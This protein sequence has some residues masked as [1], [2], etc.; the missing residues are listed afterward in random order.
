MPMCVSLA[1]GAMSEA[2]IPQPDS[3]RDC[4]MPACCSHLLTHLS[5]SPGFKALLLA[6]CLPWKVVGMDPEPEGTWRHLVWPLLWEI[7]QEEEEEG[8]LGSLLYLLLTSS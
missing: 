2:S 5:P 1:M 3:G 7:P 4:T 6:S 8:T